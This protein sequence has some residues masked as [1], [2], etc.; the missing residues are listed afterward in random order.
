MDTSFPVKKMREPRKLRH[1]DAPL[2]LGDGN[3]HGADRSPTRTSGAGRPS[4]HREPRGR[5]SHVGKANATRSR[6]TSSRSR[7]PSVADEGPGSFREWRDFRN[8]SA[9]VTAGC[10]HGR[11][12]IGRPSWA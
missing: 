5:E 12:V 9:L 11:T 8:L 10:F 1:G 4:A 7:A 3:R 6:H 2:M